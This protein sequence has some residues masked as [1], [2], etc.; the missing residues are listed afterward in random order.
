[1]RPLRDRL[2]IRRIENETKTASGLHLPEVV[3]E[4]S[5]RGEVL[6]VGSGRVTERGVLI[7]PEVKVGDRVLFGR[8]AGT[9]VKHEGETL[10]VMSESEV[11]AVLG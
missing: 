9:E 4:K 6:A 10:L 7:P 2:I 8:K 1:M 5:T 3:V 11:F